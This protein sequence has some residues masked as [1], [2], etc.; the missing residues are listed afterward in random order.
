MKKFVLNTKSESD[1]YIYFIIH[2]NEPTKHEIKDF[3]AEHASDKD[4]EDGYVYEYVES[5]YEIKE[6]EFL[7]IPKKK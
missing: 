2:P 6:E 4:D 5:I 7:T 1:K 3:L